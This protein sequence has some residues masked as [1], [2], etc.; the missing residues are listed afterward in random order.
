MLLNACPLDVVIMRILCRYGLLIGRV[1][2][3]RMDLSSMVQQLQ[4]S[5][6]LRQPLAL[7]LCFAPTASAGHAKG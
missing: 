5:L 6:P 2:T 3:H 1:D 7:W 4:L